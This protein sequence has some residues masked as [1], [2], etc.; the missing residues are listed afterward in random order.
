[1]RQLRNRAARL[2]AGFPSQLELQESGR[3]WNWKLP[4]HP[5]MVEGKYST[6][7]MK[8]E[9]AR[10]LIGACAG[11][12]KAKPAWAAGYRVTCVICLPDMFSSE[13]C[14]Y[15][16]DAYF[17]SR[18]DHGSSEDG[19]HSERI[20]GRSLAAEWELALPEGVAEMGS[21][22]TFPGYADGMDAYSGEHWLYGEC[23]E[24]VG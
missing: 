11:L 23:G 6:R 1:M 9:I 24:T 19:V 12:M 4:T 15:L 22:I 16:D 17:R 7:R 21:R 13:V 20:A 5:S 18:T 10:I 8:Q 2:E 14:I 3:Y